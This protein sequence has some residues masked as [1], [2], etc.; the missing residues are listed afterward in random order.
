MVTAQNSKLHDLGFIIFRNFFLLT[1][2]IIFAVVGLL[3]IFGASTAAIFLG[4][5]SVINISLGLVQDIHAWRALD[6]L[7]SLTA[8][9][10][11]R[12]A[13]DGLTEIILTDD[14]K[15]D[16]VIVLKIGDQVPCD[17]TLLE[18]LAFEI[19]EGLVTGESNSVSQKAGDTLLAGGVVT[20]GSGAMKVGALPHESR[21]ERMTSGIKKYS[22]NISPIQRSVETIIKIAG[23]VLIVVLAVVLMRGFLAKQSSVELVLNVAALT[24]VIVPQGLVF[25]VALFFAYGAGQL[26]KRHVLLQ[27][28]NATEKLGRIKNLCMDKTGTLTENTLAVEAMHL[29]PNFSKEEASSLVAAYISGTN[30]SSQTIQAVIKFL[31]GAFEGVAESALAFSSSR[32]YGAVIIKSGAL[33]SCILAGAPDVFLPHLASTEEKSWLASLLDEHTAGG[34]SIV[35]FARSSETLIPETLTKSR[36]SLVAVFVFHNNLRPGI[37]DTIH[38]FQER[39][40]HIR[41][42]SG[43][44]PVTVSAIAEATGVSRANLVVTGQEL[45]SWSENEYNTRTKNYTIFAQII[46]EQK[47]KII[48]AL[49]KD[50]F[51]AM[52]GDGANDAL[53]IKKADLGIAMFDGA[54]ATRQLASVVLTNNSFAALPG[55][56]ILA[57]SIIRNIEIFASIF[58]NQALLGFFFFCV[59]SVGGY[60]YP[61][62]PFNITLIN[63]C[64]V[65]MPG[66]LISYWTIRPPQKATR[67]SEAPFLKRVVPFAA[68][69]A[70]IQAF[71]AAAIFILNEK[72]GQ[73][74]QSG[75]LVLLAFS[76]LGFTFFCL[77][78]RVYNG[79]TTA[80]QRKQ[81]ALFGLVDILMLLIAFRVP[82]FFSFFNLSLVSFSPLLGGSLILSL[83]F[84]S[85]GMYLLAVYFTPKE[86]V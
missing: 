30:D 55:G 67:V 82:L 4:I 3:F 63:Y 15:K 84:S 52:V 73:A 70:V 71:G 2:A 62:T 72:Y 22:V 46:P 25:A 68:F 7:Q 28:V 17:G 56:V 19:N 21:I 36:L 27:E 76:I 8:P 45:A 26:F 34:K 50:G 77:T 37:M 39:G 18:A 80:L 85:V 83:A 69:A 48:E 32:Q 42:V 51:T 65:A 66:T 74:A 40:V 35:A 20:S 6:K 81:L 53:A 78:P 9:H 49:K 64:A 58:L 16:D 13:A 43:D 31:G 60:A 44:N 24:S 29:P 10:I 47:E 5:I 14:I 1:N 57:D 33:N 23:Y 38:F 12:R 54:S 41:I 79:V 86:L 75:T 11:T 61:L 59:V